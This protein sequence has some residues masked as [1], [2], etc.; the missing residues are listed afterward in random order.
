MWKNLYVNV[1]Y[2]RE[3]SKKDEELDEVEFILKEEQNR[4]LR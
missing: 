4:R 2:K 3:K 1:G